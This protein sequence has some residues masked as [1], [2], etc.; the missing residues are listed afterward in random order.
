[1]SI[2][3]RTERFNI[4][5]NNHGRTQTCKFFVLDWNMKYVEWNMQ[6]WMVMF[7]FSFLT[8]N[9]LFRQICFK[10]STLF[11]LGWNLVAKVK[12]AEFN[13][14]CQFKLKFGTYNQWQKWYSLY[15][16]KNVLNNILKDTQ[17]SLF[18]AAQF[19]AKLQN[20]MPGSAGHE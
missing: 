9:A 12:N 13:S 5:S 18:L 2:G 20:Y 3:P 6:N 14:D 11:L 4:V 16:H 17:N 7:T 8:R 15:F 19:C 10:K 1:M